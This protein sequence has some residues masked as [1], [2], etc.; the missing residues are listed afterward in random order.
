[1]EEKI[2]FRSNRQKK[3]DKLRAENCDYIARKFVSNTMAINYWG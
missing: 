3:A 2:D 1:M